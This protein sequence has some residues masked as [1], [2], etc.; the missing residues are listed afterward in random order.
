VSAFWF[1][2]AFHHMRAEPAFAARAM[3]R[4]VALFWNDFEI[5]DN[6]DQYVLERDSWVLRLPLLGFGWIAPLALLGALAGVRTAPAVRVLAGFVV[7]YSL[8]VV[9]FFI[10][11]RYRI[12]VVPALLPLAAL[13]TVELAARIRARDWSR[14][15]IACAVVAGAAW[16]SFHTIGIF[17]RHDP[18]AV[19]MQLAHLGNIYRVAGEPD[20]AI[21]VLQDAVRRCPRC[22]MSL[23]ELFDTYVAT[24]RRSQGEA[25]FRTFAREH[26]AHPDGAGYVV[27][28]RE[29]P[30]DQ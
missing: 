3:L 25:Y 18:I 14:V 23:G 24:G 4:K 15:A 19:D 7:L 28:L 2:E 26:P 16:F 27:R 13:G 6:Q 8:S 10:F 11:S 1:A 9:A 21:A 5:S 29:P 12:Q 20:R 17:S 22:R 30:P